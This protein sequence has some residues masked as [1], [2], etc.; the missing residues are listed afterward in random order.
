MQCGPECVC[1]SD[2]ANMSCVHQS[3]GLSPLLCKSLS[4]RV[5]DQCIAEGKF[6]VVWL[7]QSW[8]YGPM[9][10]TVFVYVFAGGLLFQVETAAVWAVQ[11][12][13]PVPDLLVVDRAQAAAIS[14]THRQRESRWA[15][16]HAEGL[17]FNCGLRRY[18]KEL[19]YLLFVIHFRSLLSIA[20][21][22]RCITI[23]GKKNRS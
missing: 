5:S 1:I 7:E 22:T 18:L 4:S 23:S 12:V 16:W 13:W 21:I 8:W 3:P 10:L 19:P 11:G 17:N 15:I 6:I 20:S 14:F 9:G 2:Y